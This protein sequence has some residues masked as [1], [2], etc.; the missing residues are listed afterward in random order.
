MRLRSWNII[1]DHSGDNVI[2]VNHRFKGGDITTTGA[3]LIWCTVYVNVSSNV[4]V[5]TGIYWFICVNIFTILQAEM[6]FTYDSNFDLEI[7]TL[8]Y[9]DQIVFGTI[10][11]LTVSSWVHYCF[12][13]SVWAVSEIY[14]GVHVCIILR[15]IIVRVAIVPTEWIWNLCY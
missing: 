4:Q 15:V 5:E 2:N 8:I 14:I 9:S 1:N 13:E 7:F 10:E 6:P 11:A 3:S 12:V